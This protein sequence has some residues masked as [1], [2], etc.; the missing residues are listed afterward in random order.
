MTANHAKPQLGILLSRCVRVLVALHF[1]VG[2][3]S[4]EPETPPVEDKV[5][6]KQLYSF[7]A[8]DLELKTA[9]ALFA[10]ANRLNVIPDHD[11]AGKV[12]VDFDEVSLA[13][14]MRAILLAND[15][16]WQQEGQLIEV[17]T[18][19]TRHF[20]V[21]YLRLSRKGSGSSS[22]TLAA[23]G[24]A[25]AGA[26]A[27]SSGSA[28]GSSGSGGAS[29]GGAG[30]MINVQQDNAVDFWKELKEELQHV[31]T[32][33]GKGSLAVN[34]TAGMIQVTDRP[35]ALRRVAHYLEGMEKTVHRQV[36]IEAK[37][38]DVILNDQFQL[39][40][41]WQHM[42]KAYGGSM[43]FGGAPGV[44]TPGGGFDLK[45]ASLSGGFQN[46]NTAVAVKA[47][48]EQGEVRVI[49][50]PSIRTL[51]NQTALIKVGSETPFFTRNSVFLPGNA[52]GSTTTIQEDQVNT[53][54]VG[55]VL[56]ITPQVASD[57]WI[58][59]DISPVLTSLV[60]TRLSPSRTTTA[61]VLDIK[62][63]STLIRIRSGETAVMGGL[64]Q[65]DATKT[66][67]SIPLLADIPL[68]GKLFQGD[69]R[70]NRK[71]ELIIFVTP[72]LVD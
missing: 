25:G 58:T 71:R 22:A 43:T 69:M 17:R 21:N 63:A 39:G 41:D 53:V 70:G 12:T 65:N 19:E 56:A 26:G 40:V 27:G 30:S 52:A 44:L 72:T 38:Y 37:L 10:R 28:A 51:N 48:K 9:L 54:T 20:Q 33:R 32:E 29:G 2:V 8:R 13:E 64:I 66:T 57:D 1:S 61:P 23:P 59:L 35:S 4:A 60:E 3:A 67:R 46:D 11:V 34:M 42:A 50:K 36:N 6:G 15:C 47:L 62:Q 49:S 18:T 55:T 24:G 14:A 31:L 45:P 5:A 68:L 16:T 7:H